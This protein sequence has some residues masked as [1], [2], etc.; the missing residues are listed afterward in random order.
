MTI[1]PSFIIDLLGKKMICG[2]PCD[3]YN[4]HILNSSLTSK[5]YFNSLLFYMWLLYLC[6]IVKTKRSLFLKDL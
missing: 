2:V 4:A 3:F 1:S 5:F 6:L